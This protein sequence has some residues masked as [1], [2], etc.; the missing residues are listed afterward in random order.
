MIERTVI[1][2]V[3]QDT[4]VRARG[5]R[6][7]FALGHH[8]E[9][10]TGLGEF[11][12]QRP[13]RGIVLLRDDSS[14]DIQSAFEL[15]GRCGIWL[16][17][18]VMDERPDIRRVVSA[19]KSGALDYLELP[20]LA[21]RLAGLLA[22]IDDEAQAHAQAAK[23]LIEARER[24]SRLSMR[25][26]EVL[27]WLAL[28]ST[29]KTIARELRISPRTVEIHRANMMTKLGASH[30]AEVIKLRLDAGPDPATC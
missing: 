20:I 16:P 29:N 2:I 3:D 6:S 14:E 21:E 22:R 15:L 1:H 9:V 17:V 12:E 30:A 8:A 7:A 10:Y 25:E 4:K 11:C 27:N 24:I 19:I 26:R 5:A 28:G 13:Q 23:T 18:V